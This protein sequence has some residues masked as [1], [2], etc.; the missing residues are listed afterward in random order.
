MF[1]RKL[2]AVMNGKLEQG[3]AMNALAHMSI[4]F[5]SAFEPEQLEITEYVDADMNSHANI[6]KMPYIILKAK[7]SNKIS[8]LRKAAIALGIEFVVYTDTMTNG[9]YQDQQERTASTSEADL[10]YYG[11][12]L[13]GVW[14][15]VAEL[16]RKFSLWK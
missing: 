2:V 10:E 3:V 9:S 11:I 12:V 6:S 14:E 4:G 5:G 13:Y 8:L 15:Q 16:T 7:N 1:D